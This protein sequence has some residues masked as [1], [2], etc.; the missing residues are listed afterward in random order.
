VLPA[1]V[2]ISALAY[3]LGSFPTG[4]IAGRL[5][6][7]DIRSVGSGNVGATNVTRVLG[8][9]FGYPVFVLD[10]AKGFVSVWAGVLIAKA[11]RSNVAFVDLCAASAA[12]LAVIGHSYSIWLRFNGGKGVATSLGSLFAMN[13]IAAV[14]VCVLWVLLFQTTR[15]VSLASLTAALALPITMA[16]LFFLNR[17]QTPILP[18][19]ALALAAIVIWRHRS[20][21]SRL[22]NGTEPRFNRK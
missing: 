11:A 16:G 2:T 14:V 3:L 7:V 21:I 1:F 13:W 17:L 4:Y 19:F 6:G 18:G 20:N 22:L 9:R 12:V 15:Y 8:K 10:F 5:A